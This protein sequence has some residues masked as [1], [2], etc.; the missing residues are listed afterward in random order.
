MKYAVSGSPKGMQQS[1]RKKC[2]KKSGRNGKMKHL[3]HLCRSSL[4]HVLSNQEGSAPFRRRRGKQKEVW[5]K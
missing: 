1:V 5:K 2:W 4:H 3:R